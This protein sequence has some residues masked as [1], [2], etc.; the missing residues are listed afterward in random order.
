[1]K[2][3]I[4]IA[5]LI[6]LAVGCVAF[7]IAAYVAATAVKEVTQQELAPLNAVPSTLTTPQSPSN[8]L[9]GTR[10][11]QDLAYIS[12]DSIGYTDDADPQDDGMAIDLSFYDGKSELLHFSDVPV[13]VT[14]RLYG[15]HDALEAIEEGE[16][17]LVYEASLQVDH[18]MRLGEMFGQYIRI[19]YEQ[20][21]VDPQQY[22]QFG[23]LE[24]TILTPNGVTM[25]ATSDLPAQLYA[26]P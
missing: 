1:M 13:Q 23:K 11:I 25:S 22:T 8:S 10:S 24:V 12:V 21:H 16:G 14:I 9:E 18:S 3:T 15:Y 20:I 4:V 6:V 7:G 17:E 2:K 26:S 5:L 19:P